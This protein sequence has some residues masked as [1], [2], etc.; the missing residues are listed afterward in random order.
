MPPSGCYDVQNK[1]FCYG[2]NVTIECPETE[3]IENRKTIKILSAHFGRSG[4]VGERSCSNLDIPHMSSCP[5]RE[6]YNQTRLRC[7]GTF[8]CNFNVSMFVLGAL[9]SNLDLGTCPLCRQY[10]RISYVC[11]SKA[12]KNCSDLATRQFQQPYI[13]FA[14]SSYAQPFLTNLNK[15]DV[16]RK[17]E[18][19]I[20]QAER[21]KYFPPTPPI[22]EFCDTGKDTRMGSIQRTVG[23]PMYAFFDTDGLQ[24]WCAAPCDLEN[25]Y[26]Q[27]DLGMV[28]PITGF[29]IQ[30][31]RSQNH[32]VSKFMLSYSNDGAEWQK[33]VENGFAK[34]FDGNVNGWDVVMCDMRRFQVIAR[35][36]RMEVVSWSGHPCAHFEVVR[37][38]NGTGCVPLTVK[39]SNMLEFGSAPDKMYEFTCN[40]GWYNGG[41]N[42]YRAMLQT[43]TMNCSTDFE[44]Q[45][46]QWQFLD[47][48]P[49][50]DYRGCGPIPEMSNS[51]HYGNSYDFGT[52]IIYSCLDGQ[53]VTGNISIVCEEDGHWSDFSVRCDTFS[54]ITKESH[55]HAH[56]KGEDHSEA[57]E[58]GDHDHESS[59]QLGL[60]HT[61]GKQEGAGGWYVGYGG[62]VG[63]MGHG[64]GYGGGGPIGQIIDGHGAGSVGNIGFGGQG[65]GGL[66]KYGYGNFEVNHGHPHEI[67][68]TGAYEGHGHGHENGAGY[69]GRGDPSDIASWFQHHD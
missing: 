46:S 42:T 45:V 64:H 65:L 66:D 55:W 34:Q 4:R 54:D 68:G 3:D 18:D 57:H 36:I 16:C 44:N 63:S 50:S 58:D 21:N 17:N 12:Q 48:Y 39:N 27:I 67:E 22:C 37:C 41:N 14:S 51:L 38:P 53:T 33:V 47:E 29:V 60:G 26:L 24:S 15:T 11:L 19:Q 2:E 49:C 1:E 20:R 25:P 56:S 59:W 10:M 52:E 7:E 43:F 23:H 31:R 9:P 62:E 6:V 32:Y 13:H 30:G 69:G 5:F 28:Y 61:H 40:P 35:Y 8:L